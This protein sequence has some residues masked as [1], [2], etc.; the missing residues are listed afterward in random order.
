MQV[1][2]ND[3]SEI[4]T[5]GEDEYFVLPE[6]K[7]FAEIPLPESLTELTPNKL[8]SWEIVLLCNNPFGPSSPRVRGGIRRVEPMVSLVDSES[9]SLRE[10]MSVYAESGL[11]YDYIS[12]LTLMKQQDP[13]SSQLMQNWEAALRAVNL[14]VIFDEFEAAE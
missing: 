12:A 4:Y 13:N 10:K 9:M 8:Y 2:A 6:G 11:W 3:G 5:Y 14:D 1:K 7:G